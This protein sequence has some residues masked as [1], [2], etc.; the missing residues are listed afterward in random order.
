MKERPVVICG[1][2]DRM[3]NSLKTLCAHCLAPIVISPGTLKDAGP[4]AEAL[5]G[6]CGLALV[7]KAKEEGDKV[8]LAC[9]PH[10]QT[11]VF[12]RLKDRFL[13]KLKENDTQK[14]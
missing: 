10:Q 14:Q 8:T 6:K 11:E 7:R 1:N 3:G 9:G 4:D 5:C 13:A 12:E 2:V